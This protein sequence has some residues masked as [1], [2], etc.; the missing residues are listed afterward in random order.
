MIHNIAIG[1]DP[2]AAGLK[3]V[4]INHL[5][6]IG[7]DVTDYGS[8][9][10]IYA[11]TAFEVAKAVAEKKHE[12]AILLCGTGLGMSLAANKVNGVYAVACSDAYSVERSIKSNN[13]NILTLGSKIVSEELAKALLSLWLLCDYDASGS[14]EPKVQR[15]Y[16]IE[17]YSMNK[18][19]DA[20]QK[21]VLI[22]LPLIYTSNAFYLGEKFYVAAGSEDRE[23]VYLIDLESTEKTK[24]ADGPGGMMS[25]LPIPGYDDKMVS[26]MGLFP[27]FIGDEAGIYLHEKKNQT[28]ETR[29]VISLPFSHRCEILTINGE[30]HLFIATVSKHKEN[31]SD[32]SRPGELHHV[33]IDGTNPDNWKT[34]IVF[35]NLIRNHGMT[36]RVVNNEEILCISGDKGIFAIK[37][38]KEDDWESIQLFDREVSEFSFFDLDNDGEDELVTI[39]P[40]HGKDL[41]IYKKNGQDWKLMY[42]SSLVFGHGLFAG[43]FK[44]EN[45]VVVGNRRASEALELHKVHSITNIE[46]TIVEDKVGPTQLK[47][48]TYKG[49][50]YILSS[51]QAKNEVALYY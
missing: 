42:N 24:I 6:M 27:P 28:W 21:K 35:E 50:D 4:L 22:E 41:N 37:K 14:S 9:D 34:D 1:C 26:V 2:N 46:K 17:K 25:M 5:K 19:F 16:E 31:P 44:G 12:R 8:D 47:I 30:N 48:F 40:F 43:K 32:W 3:E 39:E 11:N 20:L 38:G 45:V 18:S 51:N 13:V 49:L 33:K 36:K 15:I 10:P 23:A 29:K 7:C